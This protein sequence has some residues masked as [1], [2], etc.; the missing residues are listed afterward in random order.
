RHRR[1]CCRDDTPEGLVRGHLDRED[2]PLTAIEGPASP[3]D[4]AVRIRVARGDA[5]REEVSP[6]AP[7]RRRG[8]FGTRPGE[9]GAHGR[10]HLDE[11]TAADRHDRVS[12]PALLDRSS[13]PRCLLHERMRIPRGERDRGTRYVRGSA[14]ENTRDAYRRLNA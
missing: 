4:H 11:V 9:R 7:A 5:F 1:G 3:E 13:P 6:L 2:V 8:P 14:G 10:R 12:F